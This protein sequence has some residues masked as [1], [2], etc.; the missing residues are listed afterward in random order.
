MA[1]FGRGAI[2]LVD[3]SSPHFL[4]SHIFDYG[5]WGDQSTHHEPRFTIALCLNIGMQM[6]GNS[7]RDAAF[8]LRDTLAALMEEHNYSVAELKLKYAMDA[9][10]QV[11]ADRVIRSEHLPRIPDITIKRVRPSDFNLRKWLT[12]NPPA[13]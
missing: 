7:A 6:T 13:A 2:I 12:Q 11:M 3:N 9:E 4:H 8:A 1:L 5:V 10:G